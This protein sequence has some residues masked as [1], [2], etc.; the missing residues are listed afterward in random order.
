MGRGRRRVIERGKFSASE[1]EE[2]LEHALSSRKSTPPEELVLE[3]RAP[4][5]S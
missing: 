3:R 4:R 5:A 1:I 2:R